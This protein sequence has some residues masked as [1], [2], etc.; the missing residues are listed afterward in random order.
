MKY[1]LISSPFDLRTKDDSNN[2]IDSIETLARIPLLQSLDY[3]INKVIARLQRLGIMPIDSNYLESLKN[4]RPIKL[5]NR[6]M[7]TLKP[8]I[9][10]KQN[11]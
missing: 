6:K 7:L 4:G 10:I 9:K 8:I 5:N 1:E 2:S 11:N 3:N